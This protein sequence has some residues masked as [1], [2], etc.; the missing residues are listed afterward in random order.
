MF[1]SGIGSAS[2]PMKAEIKKIFVYLFSDFYA[3]LTHI[4]FH[5]IS[6]WPPNQLS[7]ITKQ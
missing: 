5:I 1:D 3:D 6:S 4:F 7:S 2:A